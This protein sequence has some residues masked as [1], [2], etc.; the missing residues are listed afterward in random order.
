MVHCI[1][2]ITLLRDSVLIALLRERYF[3]KFGRLNACMD[4]RDKRLVIARTSGSSSLAVYMFR[5]DSS[6]IASSS[7]DILLA[8]VCLA[9]STVLG[10]AEEYCS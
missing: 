4:V 1:V 10:C 6:F 9:V 7:S 3:G 5:G 2:L 8:N